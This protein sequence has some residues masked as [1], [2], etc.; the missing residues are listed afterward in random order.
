[1]AQEKTAKQSGQLVLGSGET[2]PV[3][4]LWRSDHE[5]CPD[6]PDLWLRRQ[7]QFPRCPSCGLTTSF[8]LMEEV[9]H[10]SEDPDFQ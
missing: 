1:V 7:S 6:A 10:I 5:G 9:P 3:S 8:S 4:G 2:V